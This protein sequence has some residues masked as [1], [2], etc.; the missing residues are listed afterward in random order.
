MNRYRALLSDLRDGILTPEAARQRRDDL[1]AALHRIYEDAPLPE[2]AR[3]QSARAH[4]CQLLDQHASLLRRRR[5]QLELARQLLDRQEPLVSC[6]RL[7]LGFLGE[8]GAHWIAFC[9]RQPL[10]LDSAF[11]GRPEKFLVLICEF[12]DRLEDARRLPRTGSRVRPRRLRGRRGVR[13]PLPPSAH[14]RGQ[15][16][17]LLQA[18]ICHVREKIVLAGQ[19]LDCLLATTRKLF[20]R[21][22]SLFRGERLK[23][24]LRLSAPRLPPRGARARR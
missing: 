3:Y 23:V 18:I 7:R 16:C 5:L 22:E 1:M 14:A 8:R 13:L 4:A 20:H 24:A 6:F 9:L 19:L 12:L 15:L 11:L 10:E 2:R 21:F 17:D